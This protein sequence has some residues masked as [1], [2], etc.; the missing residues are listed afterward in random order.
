ML[1]WKIICVILDYNLNSPLNYEDRRIVFNTNLYVR[2][3]CTGT[4]SLVIV[5]K[6]SLNSAVLSHH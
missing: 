1:L 3:C 4:A 6:S 2:H 5:E